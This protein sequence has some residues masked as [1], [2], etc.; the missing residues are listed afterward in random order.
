[1]SSNSLSKIKINSFSVGSRLCVPYSI[2]YHFELFGGSRVT[3]PL[4]GAEIGHCHVSHRPWP[5]VTSLFI[6]YWLTY[7]PKFKPEHARPKFKFAV[8]WPCHGSHWPLL[9][10]KFQH[11]GH[12]SQA[13]LNNSKWYT[14][15]QFTNFTF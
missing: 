9:N 14:I 2:L 5:A 15:Y 13:M 3:G 8:I 11:S 7:W 12:R 4:D 10:V 6:N 1:M